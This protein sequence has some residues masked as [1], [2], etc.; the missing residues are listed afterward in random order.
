LLGLGLALAIFFPL[1]A[2]RRARIP[3]PALWLSLILGI[4]IIFYGLSH[5]TIPSFTSPITAVGKAYDYVNRRSGGAHG[6]TYGSFRFVPEGGEA[7]HIE[8]GILLP[9][10][11]TP[12][13]FD[14]RTFRVV[15]LQDSWRALKNEAVDITIVSGKH[16]GFHESLDARPLGS[17]LAIPIGA[18]LLGFGWMAFRYRRE[19]VNPAASDGEDNSST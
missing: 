16:T 3:R 10:W 7:I 11:G 18:S 1:G 13:N 17:W 4:V 8:T 6:N 5:G 15:Y 9:D 12:A 14:G 19:D 2:K